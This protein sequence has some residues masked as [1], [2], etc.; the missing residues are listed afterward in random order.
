L[1]ADS[2]ASDIGCFA[3]ARVT[4]AEETFDGAMFWLQLGAADRVK[5]ESRFPF[6]FQILNRLQKGRNAVRSNDKQR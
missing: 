5:P 4:F 2:D 3:F 1:W 6:L